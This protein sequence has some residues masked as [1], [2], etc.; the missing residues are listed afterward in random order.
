M[1]ERPRYVQILEQ[2][3]V[4]EMSPTY[5]APGR[6]H[7]HCQD[8]DWVEGQTRGSNGAQGLPQPGR[9]LGPNGGTR[10]LLKMHASCNGALSQV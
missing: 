8:E 6:R 4:S 2:E 7:R 1:I 3:P 5:S 10:V 9:H